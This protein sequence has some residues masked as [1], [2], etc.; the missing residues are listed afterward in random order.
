M[1]TKYAGQNALNKLMQL[2]KTA[3]NS[4]ADKTNATASAAGLM[5]AADKVKLDGVEGGANKTV[6]DS[7]LSASSTNPVQNKAVKTALDGLQDKVEDYY[8]TFTQQKDSSGEYSGEYTANHTAK[9]IY[10]AYQAGKR[11]WQKDIYDRFPITAC[12]L[13]GTGEYIAYFTHFEPGNMMVCYGVNQKSDTAAS[14]ANKLVYGIIAPNPGSADNGKYLTVNG[15]KIAYTDL[16]DGITVDDAMSASSTNPVQNKVIKQYVDDHA[17]DDAVLYTAQTL[18]FEQ[19]QRARKN[20]EAAASEWPTITGAVSLCPA[21]ITDSNDA[22]HVTVTK[23]DGTDYT[24]T[25]DC[26]PE[27]ALV[28]VKGIRTPTD[29]DT[30]A[31]ATVEYVKAKVASG[32]VTVDTEMSS[33]ST[34]PVQNKVVKSYVDTK[35]SGLQTASQVQAAISSAITG[36]YTPKGSIAFASLPTA[37]AGNKGWVYNVSDAFTTTAAFVEGAGHSYGAGANVVC[38]DAGSGSYKWDVLAGIIDLTELTADEV[39]TL[40]NSI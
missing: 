20:I 17:A 24:A 10:E 28:R 34:N 21:K 13:L 37:A 40:W 25:L 31:A 35:V 22:V 38:V 26:G 18:T 9:E 8:V 19:K 33:T 1:A 30:N 32:G 27:N 7:A 36:V 29:A 14:T 5:S 2:V 4:K 23:Y 3:L 15:S 12:K 6:V 39:Q 11:V 16:P